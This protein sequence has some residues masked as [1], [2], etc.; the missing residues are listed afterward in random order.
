MV[1]AFTVVHSVGN[2]CHKPFGK[3]RQPFFSVADG[4]TR[5]EI[6]DCALTYLYLAQ[7]FRASNYWQSLKYSCMGFDA[8]RE[9]TFDDG[10]EIIGGGND[11]HI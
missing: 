11:A 7:Y 6:G 4:N 5:S 3:V 8:W 9:A 2:H 10:I 1:T